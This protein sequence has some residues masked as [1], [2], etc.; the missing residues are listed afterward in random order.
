V[1]LLVGSPAALAAR[2]RTWLTDLRAQLGNV[3]ALAYR[4]TTL[5]ALR[6]YFVVFVI[7]RSSAL[8][9]GVLADAYRAGLTIHLIG[10][11]SQYQAQVSATST[12]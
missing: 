6:A 4:D 3:D 8:D 2:E 7:D 5:D 9:P 11:A 10:A 1:A 12:P